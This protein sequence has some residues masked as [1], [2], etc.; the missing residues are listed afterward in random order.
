MESC[1]TVEKEIEKVLSKFGSFNDHTWKTLTDLIDYVQSLKNELTDGSPCF[2]SIPPE[3]E[4]TPA[5]VMVLTQCAK[6]VK[7]VVAKL[8]SEHR[9]LHGTVSKVGKAV[10][11]NFIADFAATSNEEVFSSA[12]NTQLLNQV[13]SE[14]FLRQGMLD[15]AEELIREAGLQIDND[16]KE[17]FTELNRILDALKKRDLKPAL[18]WARLNRNKL[19]EQNSSL[20]FKLHRLHFIELLQ[21]GMKHQ[22]AAIYY[23]RENFQHLASHHE[24]EIQVLM[25]SLLYLRQGVKKSPYNYLLDPIHWAEIC[26]VFTRDACALLGLSVESPL[27]VCINAGCI[28]LPALLNIKQVMQQRQVTG[29]WSTRDE[30]PI[31]I[32]LGHKCRFHSIFACP[33]LRQ[34]SSDSNPPMRLVCGHVIS[35]DALNKLANGNKLKCPYCPVEQNPADAR[36][37]H[38]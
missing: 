38:F 12:E 26:D 4:I 8:A 20:E 1:L 14:H 2:S 21:K 31:E 13:I 17:P 22:E 7:D 23:A 18:E 35:R 3:H 37:I 6:K 29:V 24:K 33:I 9:D 11:K 19:Q 32:D 5:Q 36:L 10:D 28:A 25:G 15:I 16:K 27:T 34:Q 30:L